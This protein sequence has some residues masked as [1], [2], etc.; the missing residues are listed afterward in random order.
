MRPLEISPKVAAVA[1][2]LEM[3]PADAVV[4]L[5][6]EMSPKAEVDFPIDMSPAKAEQPSTSVR[7]IVALSLRTFFMDLSPSKGSESETQLLRLDTGSVFTE[8]SRYK[9][10]DGGRYCILSPAIN[11]VR[12]P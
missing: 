3:S 6:P 11:L 12:H 2:P 1:F 8:Q 10:A 5:P 9:K 4:A 7:I